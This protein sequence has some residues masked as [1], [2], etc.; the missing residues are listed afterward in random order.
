[1]KTNYALEQCAIIQLREK[2]LFDKNHRK[3]YSPVTGNS[4]IVARYLTIIATK[5]PHKRQHQKEKQ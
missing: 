5:K 4:P 1:M 3:P 2:P